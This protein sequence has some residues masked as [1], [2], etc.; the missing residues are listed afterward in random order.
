M[1]HLFFWHLQQ[2]LCHMPMKAPSTGDPHMN[3]TP[4]HVRT[5][6]LRSKPATAS[7]LLTHAHSYSVTPWQGGLHSWGY[8]STE[9]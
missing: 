9:V 6:A 8:A 3:P 1:R 7:S 5:A 4:S 2:I